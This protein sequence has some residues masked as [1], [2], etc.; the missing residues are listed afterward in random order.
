MSDTFDVFQFDG[1]CVLS[2]RRGLDEANVAL[3][4]RH[5]H[6]QLLI[7]YLQKEMSTDADDKL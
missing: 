6:Q 3:T 4:P 1:I 2:E 5:Q 7:T